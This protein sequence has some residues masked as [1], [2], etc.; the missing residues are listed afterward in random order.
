[1]DLRFSDFEIPNTQTSYI[2]QTFTMPSGPNHVIAIEPIISP[3]SQPFVHH[4]A[5]QWCYQNETWLKSLLKF[6]YFRVQD[7]VKP[8]LCYYPTM[9]KTCLET[10]YGW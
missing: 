9:Y 3:A 8:S 2:C 4:F 6:L 7:H 5:L 10:V 1:M